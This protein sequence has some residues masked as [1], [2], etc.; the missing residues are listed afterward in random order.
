MARP[1][2][3]P[4][5][6]HLSIWKWGP[7]MAISI[8]NRVC[9]VGLATLGTAMFVWWLAALAGGPESYANFHYWVVNAN[10]VGSGGWV[11]N[12]LAKVVAI[13]M[14]WAFFT[15][16]GNGV[17]HFWMDLGAGFELKRN[18]I[19]ALGVFAFGIVATA[20]TWAYIFSKGA[21]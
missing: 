11:V 19:G 6:P 4:L 8:V 18:R 7:H 14:T 21:M 1:V 9:G 20:L 12:I 2:A 3:R 13:G 5:S 17:R 10:D 15:H 16:M